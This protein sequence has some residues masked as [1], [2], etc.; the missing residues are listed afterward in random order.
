MKKKATGLLFGLTGVSLLTVGFSAWIITGL[1]GQNDTSKVTVDVGD[2]VDNVVKFADV[3]VPDGNI[4]FDALDGASGGV[5]KN[6]SK[7]DVEDMTFKVTFTLVNALKADGTEFTDFMKTTKL[8]FGF[9][10]GE[11]DENFQSCITEKYIVSPLASGTT[12]D[13]NFSTATLTAGQAV[14]HETTAKDRTYLRKKVTL[15]KNQAKATD[16]DVTLDF[17]F[18]WGDYFNKDNPCMLT[19]ASKASDYLTKL[20][21]LKAKLDQAQFT[22]TINHVKASS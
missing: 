11:K 20:G 18:G 19:E 15:A 4:R 13:I 8:T 17:G 2:T 7:T 16:C 6:D 3:K 21:D 5:I 22:L 1:A 9:S 12:D 10:A 14:N